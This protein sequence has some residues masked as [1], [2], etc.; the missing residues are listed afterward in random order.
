M[1]KAMYAI[2]LL[3][4]CLGTACASIY[5]KSMWH[6]EREQIEQ[7][8]S[9]TASVNT[10]SYIGT[11]LHV[12]VRRCDL[13]SA[14]ALLKRGAD[15]RILNKDGDPPLG[16]MAMNFGIRAQGQCAGND[17]AILQLF[18][19]NG[20]KLSD[21]K[22]GVALK[23]FAKYGGNPTMLAQ[24]IKA[25]ADPNVQDADGRTP[26][27]FA[28]DGEVVRQLIALGANAA[29]KD[30]KGISV[31]AAVR[32]RATAE[33]PAQSAYDELLKTVGKDDSVADAG[34]LDAPAREHL[35]AA[36]AAND[37]NRKDAAG[38]TPL[39][40]AVLSG[41]Y[42]LVQEVLKGKPDV[43]ATNADDLTPLFM[44]TINRMEDE[45]FRPWCKNCILPDPGSRILIALKAAGANL[46]HLSKTKGTVA[47]AAA[48]TQQRTMVQQLHAQGV[49]FKIS[50][51]N[52][53]QPLC[54]AGD[55]R[56]ELA[57]W[58]QADPSG[59]YCGLTPQEWAGD[60]RSIEQKVLAR[61]LAEAE[62]SKS[63]VTAGKYLYMVQ[64]QRV[65]LS[66]SSTPK[67]R[68]IGYQIIDVTGPSTRAE[69]EA[70]VV[71]RELMRV[72]PGRMEMGR[73]L[74]RCKGNCDAELETVREQ[75]K[76]SGISVSTQ[77][78]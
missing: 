5:W 31:I 37:I 34:V 78:Y 9:D 55:L 22:D 20:Y 33:K 10:L 65:T 28:F 50:D 59:G 29:V 76:V 39:H 35:K 45:K 14:A 19:A 8:L 4:A 62:K 54:K 58:S 30:A 64:W 17:A 25:G 16:V 47:H 24:L 43:N 73:S 23:S 15:M 48:R 68:E 63:E 60:T 42:E 46:N 7:A 12:A 49:D 61:G 56:R 26:L 57:G 18:L 52:G 51:H 77:Q 6:D 32:E 66:L 67:A 74:N 21:P 40:Y 72:A 1:N 36:L 70:S 3:T 41:S 75:L 27:F 11:A 44:L 69:L 53:L 71:D 13:E 38:N 2:I